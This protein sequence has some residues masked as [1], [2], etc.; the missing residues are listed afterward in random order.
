VTGRTQPGRGAGAVD[1]AHDVDE[2]G[3]RVA[4]G[5]TV[6]LGGRWWVPL[7]VG[8]GCVVIAVVLIVAAIDVLSTLDRIT[9]RRD[10]ALGGVA[11]L[12]CAPILLVWG[13]S[14]LRRAMRQRR[15]L[16]LDPA[17]IAIEGTWMPREHVLATGR[18]TTPFGAARLRVTPVGLAL[19]HGDMGPLERWLSRI[20]GEIPH[21]PHLA[22]ITS[23]ATVRLLSTALGIE[24][25]EPARRRR[26]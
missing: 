12:A 14:K 15:A 20:Q 11:M 21:V 24:I 26:P 6:V 16:V 19:W 17:G 22:G 10:G 25:D 8:L 13:A 7:S 5:E 2:L 18:P 4:A 3:R 1:G 23:E 9:T